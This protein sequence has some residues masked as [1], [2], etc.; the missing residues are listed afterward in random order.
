MTAYLLVAGLGILI[1]AGTAYAHAI[2]GSVVIAA[3]ILFSAP[4]TWRSAHHPRE[5]PI[6]SRGRR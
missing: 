6:Q 2:A 5:N 4:C 3:L 1:Y